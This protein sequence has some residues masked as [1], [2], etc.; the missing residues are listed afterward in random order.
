MRTFIVFLLSAAMLGQAHPVAPE[1]I[2]EGQ[3]LVGAGK[4]AEAQDLYER[5]MQE[6]P[7]DADLP[8]ELGMIYFRQ[9]DWQR[10]IENYNRSLSIRPGQVK[11]LFYLAES[12]RAAEDLERAEETILQAAHFAPNDAQICQKYGEYLSTG[13]DTRKMAVSWLEKARSL[14]PKLEHIDFEIGKAEFELTDF[15][16]A[17]RNFELEL[18]K[19]PRHPEASF[20]LAESWASLGEWAKARDG[21]ADALTQGYLEGPAYYGLGKSRL[22]LEQPAAALDPL[23]RSLGLQPSLIQ[24]HFQLARAYREL[25]RTEE[26]RRENELF[27]AMTNRIDTSQELHD[28]VQRQAWKQVRPLLEGAKEREAVEYLAALPGPA[29]VANAY[30]LLGV[31]YYSMGRPDDS[32]RALL[33]AKSKAPQDAHYASY[34]GIVQMASGEAAAAE[35]T[36]EASLAIDPSDALALIG[37]GTVKY[38]QQQ[39]DLAA[40]YLEKSRTADAGVLYMLCDAYFRIRKNDRA[41]LTAEVIRAFGSNR[42]D[43]LVAVDDLVKLHPANQ[44]PIAPFTQ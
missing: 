6:I 27:A 28:A 17:T 42:K 31:M 20:F 1:I 15:P 22:Q 37:L 29:P 7:D 21:Y 8:F 33:M 43:L 18:Q 19:Y 30:Y 38:R 44:P 24:A 13:L 36:F 3:S 16:S 41:M 12:F 26:S 9:H 11:T 32:K 5:A 39:W 25:G 35:K 34:L 40:H 4:L 10:A 14:N 23:L 2:Q